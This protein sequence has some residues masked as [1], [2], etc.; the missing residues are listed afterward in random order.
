[1]VVI[2]TVVEQTGRG[3]RAFDIYSRLLGHRVVF[4]G[5]EVDAEVA[6]LLVA[7]L[8]HLES[9]E[10]GKDISIYVNSPGGEIS[11]MLAVYDAVQHVRPQVSTVCI[12]LAA[13]AAAVILAGGASG[14]RYALPHARVLIHQPHLTGGLEGQ[15]SDIAIHAR[16]IV[17]QKE[18]MIRLL[19]VHTGQDV[20]TIRRDTDRDRWMAAE[21]AVEYGIVDAILTPAA[22]PGIAAVE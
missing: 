21:E 14:K 22:V 4:L 16:E 13:S 15:A 17:R 12:G 20:E 1:M 7:Q 3:E 6:N 10:P 18:Q 5:R 9:E 19:A 8:I 11:A 2:P